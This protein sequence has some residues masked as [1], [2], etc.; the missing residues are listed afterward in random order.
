MSRCRFSE[1]SNEP[2][3]TWKIV[4]QEDQTCVPQR[5]TMRWKH[6]YFT[7]VYYTPD[8][9]FRG[10]NTAKFHLTYPRYTNDCGHSAKRETAKILVK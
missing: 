5:E 7:V 4:F 10:Q 6:F 9:G 2:T 1:G 3:R 8:R